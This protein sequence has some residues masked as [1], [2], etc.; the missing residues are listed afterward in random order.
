[1]QAARAQEITARAGVRD[2]KLQSELDT[3]DFNRQMGRITSAAAIQELQHILDTEKLTRAQRRQIM[4]EIHG[5]Q[6]DLVSQLTASG[7][8]IP[9]SVQLPTAYQVRRSLGI[10]HARTLVKNSVNDLTNAAKPN[11]F[12]SANSAASNSTP[13]MLRAMNEVRD[14][15]AAKQVNVEQKNTFHVPTAA[16]AKAI[17]EQVIAQINQQNGQHVRANTSTPRL[18]QTR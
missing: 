7:F 5:L 10:D 3:I 12:A 9:G 17:A 16:M 18:V 11:A 13:A 2:A 15:I 1:M 8:N 6:Q 4:L 14:A